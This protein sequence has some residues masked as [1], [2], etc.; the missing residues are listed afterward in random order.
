MKRLTLFFVVV[1]ATIMLFGATQ[2]T[3]QKK[4]KKEVIAKAAEDLKWADIKIAPDVLYAA[5]TGNMEKGA[6]SG[7]VKLPA[8]SKHPFHTHTNDVSCVIISGTF[9]YTPEGGVEKKLGPGSYLF[10]PSGV[11]HTSGVAEGADC[12]L[13]QSGPGKFDLIPITDD[14]QK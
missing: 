11:R 3:A 6:Y 14:A 9:L 8:G 2:S 12:V 7:F 4:S 13:F 1:I 10:I 5:V